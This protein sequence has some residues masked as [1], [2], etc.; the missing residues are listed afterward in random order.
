MRAVTSEAEKRLEIINESKS[1]FFEK[2]KKI[3]KLLAR[4]FQKV[5]QT[6]VTNVRNQRDGI[7][8][9]YSESQMTIQEY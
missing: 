8:T 5:E 7:A 6:H 3:D 4:L 1:Q 2:I 9:D